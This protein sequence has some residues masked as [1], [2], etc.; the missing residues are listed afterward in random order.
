MFLWQ[1]ITFT[2]L[3]GALVVYSSMI[4][5]RLGAANTRLIRIEEVLIGL[6]HSV[7]L[8]DIRAAKSDVSNNADRAGFL[9][10]R[11]LK[12]GSG[13]LRSGAAHANS[14]N[15]AV[16]T[17]SRGA[18]KTTRAP[19]HS[20]GAN[21]E[22]G[23]SLAWSSGSREALKE[24][25]EKVSPRGLRTPGPPSSNSRV[26]AE[27]NMAPPP[28]S[29]PQPAGDT[30]DVMSLETRDAPAEISEPV[31]LMRPPSGDLV[32]TSSAT[33]ALVETSGEVL[34][35][36]T[37]H[38][39]IGDSGAI[40]LERRD[41]PATIDEQPSM[42]LPPSG[43]C[44]AT[45]LA[46]GGDPVETGS[47]PLSLPIVEAESD[48]SGVMSLEGGDT[49]SGLHGQSGSLGLAGGD[50]S[51]TGPESGAPPQTR[52]ES[53][54]SLGEE[55]ANGISVA[56]LTESSDKTQ[57]TRRL[58]SPRSQATSED[59]VAKG[60]RDALLYLSNQRRRRRARQSL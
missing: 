41:A 17:E 59:S 7:N 58:Q 56:E 20:R 44:A 3:I 21:A 50:L 37:K 5:R 23:N 49:P 32:A 33:G 19:K 13:H 27:T 2:G 51:T 48:D 10:V 1:F 38:A 24:R 46:N 34:S 16:V 39:L 29:P 43:D 55:C 53:S 60:N 11:D 8:P 47:E 26:P 12:A 25:S 54:S 57:T 14:R 52:S 22:S 4:T 42:M 35:L 36:T 6:N 18:R 28:L 40:S 15:N 31:G 30:S 45:S 9:T